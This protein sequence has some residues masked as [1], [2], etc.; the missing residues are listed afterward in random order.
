MIRPRLLWGLL[1]APLLA[2]IFLCMVAPVSSSAQYGYPPPPPGQAPG[3]PPGGPPGP[4]PNQRQWDESREPKVPPISAG[5]AWQE[6][7]SKDPMTDIKRARFE[8]V[9]DNMLRDSERNPRINIF[10][11]NG[12][13]S[14]AHF[15]PGVRVRPDRPGFW[16]QPQLEVRVRAG[17]NLDS[18]GWN[19]DGTF[20]SMD[21][22]SVRRLVGATIF[23]IQLPGPT[24]PDNIASFSPAGLNMDQFESAC[25][26]KPKQ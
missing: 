23:K 14:F 11:E 17:K 2:I 20:L 22:D 6:Y 13:Y 18:H 7:D 19:W 1:A 9:G 5:G 8:I 16:G 26:L 15:V 12:N 10:C 25:H 24:T 4:P 21:K 3:P